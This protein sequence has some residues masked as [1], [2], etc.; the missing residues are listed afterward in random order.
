MFHGW[1]DIYMALL[2][3][4][5]TPSTAESSPNQKLFSRMTNN[6]YLVFNKDVLKPKVVQNVH[7]KLKIKREQQKYYADKNSIERSNTFEPGDN[8]RVQVKPR[9]WVKG[10]IVKK[11]TIS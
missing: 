3:Y 11:I 9:V 2:N 6:P 7:L 1:H 10:T 5:N 8:V 4:R